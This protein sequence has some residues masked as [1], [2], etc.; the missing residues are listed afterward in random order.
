[1]LTL[2]AY[3]RGTGGPPE[4][5]S[6]LPRISDV[7]FL[8]EH[9]RIGAGSFK[10]LT[11]DP[12]LTQFPDI[13]RFGNLIRVYDDGKPV[14]WWEINSE[15][16]EV[17]K[18]DRTYVEVTGVGPL[19][20]LDNAM[21]YPVT[22]VNRYAGDTRYFNF[23]APRG[24]WYVASQWK[25]T[26][27]LEALGT[28]PSNYG[29][30]GLPN[31]DTGW[32]AGL[33][34]TWI[35]DRAHSMAVGAPSGD[36]YFRREFTTTGTT[37]KK[38]RIFASV[39]DMCAVFVDGERVLSI[40]EFY[41][42]RRGFTTDVTLAPGTHVLA[43]QARNQGPV[44]TVSSGNPASLVLAMVDVTTT[45][46]V[47]NANRILWTGDGGW[48][49]MGY[50]SQ[51]PG[52]SAGEVVKILTSEAATRGQEDM[53]RLARTFDGFYDS[54]GALWAQH[55]DWN[56][57]VG[58]PLADVQ[59]EM[60]EV[61]SDMWVDT[62]LRLNMCPERGQDLTQS[63]ALY[64]SAHIIEAKTAMS[65]EIH[66]TMLVKTSDGLIETFAPDNSRLLYGRRESFMS[67]VNASE[68][69]LASSLIAQ[70]FKKF[71]QPKRTPT[72]TLSVTLNDDAR[73]WRAFNVGDWIMAPS[74]SDANML[75]RRRVVSIAATNADN[76]DTTYQ[77]EVD[78]IQGLEGER[79]ARW[80][81]S[82]GR[83]ALSGGAVGA[84]SS[85]TSALAS[86]LLPGSAG[87]A[88]T[89]G[90]GSGPAGPS[91][92]PGMMWRG[93]W[94]AA[95]TYQPSDA[96]SYGGQSWIAVASSTNVTPVQGAVWNLIAAAGVQGP[97][98][99]AYVR[100]TSTVTTPSI[101]N[102]AVSAGSIALAAGYA[103]YKIQVDRACRVRLYATTAARDADVAGTGA[104]GRVLDLVATAAGTIL[105]TPSV[106][107]WVDTGVAIPFAITNTSGATATVTLTATYQRVE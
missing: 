90:G 16:R 96:V 4:L 45:D 43:V 39:D 65:G 47:S 55:L 14:G 69:G 60:N 52:F 7:K 12:I 9:N 75:A 56:Y 95:T 58:A 82:F 34:A 18:D 79:L 86:G 99:P 19:S 5:I 44:G 38:V 98:G 21:V 41:A 88:I 107:G 24:D 73:P 40:T 64:G 25:A 30:E 78:T 49:C 101:A 67:A 66:N 32:P 17:V 97:A 20:W 31:D 77:L 92:P 53:A 42:F 93:A 10:I 50:P 76:G 59:A 84:Q 105:V 2:K 37:V 11:D 104:A 91:G 106:V 28:L 72:F 89:S 85:G 6:E 68:T 63:V 3:Y 94:A 103:L 57:G 87:S 48:L 33:S 100:A 54:K 1:M 70:V 26:V 15:P 22:G 23:G 83:G 74:D 46:T 8:E 61:V 62:D 71:S 29:R 80:I 102:T 81:E 13:I 51:P 36:V 27:N 35:W